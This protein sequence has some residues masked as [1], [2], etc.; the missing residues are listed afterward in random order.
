MGLDAHVACNC[1]RDGLSAEPPVPRSMLTVNECGDV[2][3]IDEQN[4][5]FDMANDVYDW[6]IH[7]CT[8]E[9]MKFVSEWV[10]N[11]SGVAW[12]RSV[13]V[14]LPVD[15]FGNLAMIL[16]GLSGLMDSYTP[17]SEIR[18]ALP[19]LE[20]LLQEGHLGSTRTIS[21]L[22]GFVVENKL[23]WGP[24]ALDEFH[25]LGPSPYYES[26]WPDLVELGVIGYE[27]VVRSR[28]QPANELLRTRILEQ[29]WDPESVEFGQAPDG[30]PTS[31][32]TFT[33]LQTMESV[34]ARSFGV[35]A[36][37]PQLGRVLAIADKDEPEPALVYP[38]TLIVGERRV[39][40]TEA[41]W[42]LKRLHRLFAA[43]AATGN[44]VV[45]H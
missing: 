17:A 25:S 11:I 41:W 33:N 13:A 31:R 42:T 9:D 28:E 36:R 19:E 2:E 7:A 23:D 8:H 37:L 30:R 32:I 4:C 35:S 5:D 3:L 34:T 1:F 14:G 20:L 45:W 44:P 6:T 40:L 38:E 12:L 21:T 22:S 26:P 24:I 39:M 16:A 18:R 29:K 27:F 15:R 43:S 10:G